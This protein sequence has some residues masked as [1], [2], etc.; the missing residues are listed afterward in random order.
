MTLEIENN[1]IEH[2]KQQSNGFSNEKKQIDNKKDKKNKKDKNN[3]SKTHTNKYKTSVSKE[4]ATLKRENFEL[5]NIK[6]KTMLLS[7][8]ATD[9]TT[10]NIEN[11][12]K[13]LEKE[14]LHN[15]HEPWIKLDKTIK[16]RK[17]TTYVDKLV[18]D[19]KLTNKEKNEL[20]QY[21]KNSLDRNKLQKTK[22]VAYDTT[23]G[24]ITNIPLLVFNKKTRK[25]VLHRTDK[26]PSTIKHLAPKK[27]R[28]SKTKRQPIQTD[29]IVSKID[30][31]K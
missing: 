25:F 16:L 26:K 11:V 8:N 7:G 15:K 21:F 4:I 24:I 31:N 3:D 29:D 27:N 2:T 14:T 19:H 9:T 22:D 18:L 10:S 17:L 12:N 1:A 30:T 6:Y 13:I 28:K 23:N 5:K 20:N